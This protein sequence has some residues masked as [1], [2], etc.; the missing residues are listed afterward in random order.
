[1]ELPKE[2]HLG[3]CVGAHKSLKERRAALHRT[4]LT[5]GLI[6]RTAHEDGGL[7]LAEIA[8]A[9]GLSEEAVRTAIDDIDSL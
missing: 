8:E 3:A 9:V 4:S 2:I 5:R 1:M 6:F 7:S